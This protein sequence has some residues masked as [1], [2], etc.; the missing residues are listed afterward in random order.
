MTFHL[1]QVLLVATILCGQMSADSRRT[2]HSGYGTANTFRAFWNSHG[3]KDNRSR[4]R[5]QPAQSSSAASS[6]SAGPAPVAQSQAS[7]SSQRGPDVATGSPEATLSVTLNEWT[8]LD[9][10]YRGVRIVRET[11]ATVGQV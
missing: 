4:S 7:A 5:G 6:S 1:V 9:E 2:D 11:F 8:A 3:G 10:E